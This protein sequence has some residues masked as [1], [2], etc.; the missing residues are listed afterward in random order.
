MKSNLVKISVLLIGLFVI[1]PS[2]FAH[3]AEASVPI[4]GMVS[5][6]F[7]GFG[8]LVISVVGFILFTSKVTERSADVFNEQSGFAGYIARMRMFSYNARLYMIHVVGMDVIHG[9]WEVVFNLYLL[10]VGF[11][12]TF[13]GLRILLRASSSALMSIP[14]GIISDRIGRKMSFILGDGM[15][16]AM[17]LLAIS[18]NN[19]YLILGAAVVAGFF[20]SLHGVSEPAFMAENSEDYERIHLFSVAD[21]TRTAASVIGSVLAGLLPLLILGNNPEAL[22]STYRMV[23]YIGI[24]IW[25]ASLIPAVM[26]KTKGATASGSLTL[27][28]MFSN[29]KHPDRI[30]KLSV[31]SALL[32]LGAGFTLPLMNVYF[33]EGLGRAEVEIGA[34]F[35]AGSALLVIA[36]FMAPLIAARLGKVRAIVTM[37]IIS[38][39]F[40]FLLGYADQ[41]GELAGS[42]MLVA[43]LAY[44]ARITTMDVTGPIREAFGMEILD[45][46]E[47]GTQVGIQRALSGL[48]YGVAAYFGGLMMNAGNYQSPFLIMAGI[49]IVSIALFWYFFGQKT[50]DSIPAAELTG[51]GTD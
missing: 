25:F 18:T 14:A 30:F 15:G 29:I 38:V 17:S 49:Y 27:R 4:A 28:T 23:A 9:T 26:L 20:G 43:V 40:I 37:Q 34:I 6:A 50:Q 36:S 2:V 51:Q 3:E 5:W 11:D 16:A 19:P 47:R 12:A 35:A 8:L 39:P 41:L 22:V 42:V 24:V 31:P 44:A 10:T 33:H 46:S 48:F 45:P 7:L 13:V 1:A 32:A 21:G